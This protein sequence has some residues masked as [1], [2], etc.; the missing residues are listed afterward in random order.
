M[1][2]PARM[3]IRNVVKKRVHRTASLDRDLPFPEWCERNLRIQTMSGMLV[4]LRMNAIQ[5]KMHEALEVAVAEGRT[6]HLIVKPRQTGMS[7]YIQ[8]RLFRQIISMP[9]RAAILAHDDLTTQKMR[10]MHKLYYQHYPN[11]P[12]QSQDN[13]RIVSYPHT[14]SE[15]MMVTAGNSNA[16]VGGTYNIVH[17]T[18]V[19][20][21]KDAGAIVS[22]LLQG[23]PPDGLVIFEST[24]CGAQGY[25]YDR[26]MEAL[27][28]DSIWTLHF[29]PW[30]HDPR[31]RLA[32]N[33]P[34]RLTEEEQALVDK[35]G[36]DDTQIAWRRMKRKELPHTFIQ[37]YPEDV[38]TCFITSGESYFGDI[39]S[40]YITPGGAEPMRGHR[41]V[42]GL[43]FGQKDDYTVLIVLDRETH[44]MVDMLR[45]RRMSWQEMRAR[46]IHVTR[47]WNN[48][49]VIGERNSIGEPNLE[50]LWGAGVSITP[51]TTTS[52][53]KTE[54][55]QALYYALHE[56]GL[57]MWGK[58]EVKK[59]FR[60]FSATQLPSGAWRYEA[61]RGHDDIVIAA[62][63]AW[64]GIHYAG[65]AMVTKI[66]TAV[67]N[68]RG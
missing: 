10:R 15:L 67:A 28:G 27:D 33:S 5:R 11:A 59:E 44:E 50:E 46:I 9:C 53:S 66:P 1:R 39:E 37:E 38:V 51:F 52:K 19:A 64:H 45:I 6:R 3:A 43:D 62:A 17:G 61:A 47:K 23:V 56:G 16:G 18:E 55:V 20:R 41:Y 4:P 36:L 14:N 32:V 29:Y 57:R 26:C 25:F 21:W 30:W 54:I 58:P 34:L 60:Q 48:C 8:A 13:A 7:T 31:Y 49:P 35:H 63:L 40:V 22:G 65:R 42:A 12:I 68:Y 24:P 2:Q